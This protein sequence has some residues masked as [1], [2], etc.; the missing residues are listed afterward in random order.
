[1]S[2]ELGMGHAWLTT[3]HCGPP[4]V[5]REN[6]G[7]SKPCLN[8][9]PPRINEVERGELGLFSRI[10]LT[11]TRPTPNV[12]ILCTSFVSNK[13]LCDAGY[14]QR[15]S[16]SQ[17]QEQWGR[18]AHSTAENK[19]RRCKLSDVGKTPN[20]QNQPPFKKKK[21]TSWGNENLFSLAGTL[22]SIFPEDGMPN[23]D[24]RSY[25]FPTI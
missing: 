20:K 5:L 3:P 14:A 8:T 16:R 21:K 4:S 18:R 1:M 23:T 6:K 11:K 12:T 22:A 13:D 2:V 15:M 17:P 19:K 24:F 7:K 10:S 9:S 25:W